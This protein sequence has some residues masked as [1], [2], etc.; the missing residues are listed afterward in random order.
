MRG[1]EGGEGVHVRRRLGG[2][3]GGREGGGRDGKVESGRNGVE[4]REV[5]EKDHG[6]VREDRLEI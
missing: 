2:R 6:K 5:S 3:E 1:R 4:V